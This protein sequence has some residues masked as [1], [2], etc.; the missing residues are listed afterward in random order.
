MQHYYDFGM[1]Y[2]TVVVYNQLMMITGITIILMLIDVDVDYDAD[3]DADTGWIMEY[4]SNI[5][6]CC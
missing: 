6:E 2:T 3:T 5:V 1:R 4:H